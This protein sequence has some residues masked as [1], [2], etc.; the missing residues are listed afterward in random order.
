MKIAVISDVHD[1]I[2]SLDRA[3]RAIR[4]DGADMLLACGDLCAP[5]VL[6]AIAEGFEGPV[7]AVFGNNDGDHLSLARVAQQA[8][9]VTL[10]GVYGEVPVDGVSVALVHYPEIARRLTTCGEFGAV[11]Y[12]HSH[13]AEIRRVDGCVAVNPGELMGRYGRVTYALYDTESGEAVLRDV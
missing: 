3:L 5:F 11:F 6:Q 10:H 9:N 13:R 2:W 8:G 1:N 7:H 4:E 12:G